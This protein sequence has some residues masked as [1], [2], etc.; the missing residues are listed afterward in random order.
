[1]WP[2]IRDGDVLTVAPGQPRA[3]EVVV[4]LCGGRLVIH[5]SVAPGCVRGDALTAGE[6]A[7]RILGVVV[8]A[9]RGRRALRLPR[10]WPL[11]LG[12]A[13][14]LA[15]ALRR[16]LSDPVPQPATQAIEVRRAR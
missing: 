8:A 16:R 4:A 14:R 6:S 15:A 12:P 5:R 10:L 13:V 3:G 7:D 9:R 2:W 11:W 1:M